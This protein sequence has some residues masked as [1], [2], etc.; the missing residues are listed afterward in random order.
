[1]DVSPRHLATL[2]AIVRLGSFGAAADAL[3]YTQSAVS[4]QVAELERR[5]GA[6]VLTRRPV[7]PTQA[8]LALLDAEASIRL[9]LVRAGSEVAALRDGVH[10]HLRIGAFVSAANSFVPA[11]LAMLRRTSPGLTVTLVEHETASAY[12]ALL[13]GELDLA[14]TFDYD[15]TP[16]PEPP[17]LTR[18]PL[19]D[20][21]VVVVLPVSHPLAD[22][23]GIDL[24]AIPSGEWITTPVTN[25]Q[26][27]PVDGLPH[28][29]AEGLLRFRGDDFRT[30]VHLVAAGLGAAL[31][32]SLALTPAT[33]GVVG[34]PVVGQPLTRRIYLCRLQTRRTPAAVERL[35][36][37]IRRAVD[38]LDS[39]GRV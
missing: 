23:P 32:P 37:C 25:D 15:R 10:G 11:A 2:E 16:Q 5:I 13:R 7:R 4:Q 38:E 1:M 34:V 31:L 6:G 18:T 21:P 20:D 19:F 14:L 35:D 24:T 39:V 36:D 30:A 9:A 26:R 33:A 29:A 3:G 22:R 28:T 8:G 17:G 12:T 27:H